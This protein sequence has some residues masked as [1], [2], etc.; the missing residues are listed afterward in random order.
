M[1]VNDV[2]SGGGD[3]ILA[4]GGDDMTIGTINAGAGDA[5]LNA[6][7]GAIDGG[8]VQGG[9]I[10]VSAFT[11]G[12]NSTTTLDT[13]PSN[14]FMN[15]TG[16]NPSGISGYVDSGPALNSPPPSDNLKAPGTVVIIGVSTFLSGEL[17]DIEATLTTAGATAS[18]Q[19]EDL[20]SMLASSTEV[21]FFMVPPL[22]IYIDMEEEEEEFEE[23]MFLMQPDRLKCYL[24][25]PSLL[26]DL[27][28]VEI[29]PGLSYIHDL[30]LDN[31]AVLRKTI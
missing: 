11:I 26:N 8:T 1:D 6:G 18:A 21:N 14:L 28:R 10:D 2:R 4:S 20:E 23:A 29:I 30:R 19:Q 17:G 9:R 15:L 27:I 7:G 25:R 16:Q 22:E 3:I 13:S 31:G 5:D 12:V 24:N